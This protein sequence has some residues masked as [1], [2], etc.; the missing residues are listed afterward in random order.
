[1]LNKPALLIHQIH[2]PEALQP[3]EGRDSITTR[4]PIYYPSPENGWQE[5]DDNCSTHWGWGDGWTLEWGVRPTSHSC[6]ILPWFGAQTWTNNCIIYSLFLLRRLC[7]WPRL[8]TPFLKTPKSRNLKLQLKSIFNVRPACNTERTAQLYLVYR[9]LNC[10]S[11]ALTK[12]SKNLWR[13]HKNKL[14][15]K[16]FENS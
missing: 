10:N 16:V 1:M 14:P 12:F 4:L 7:Y 11:V 9:V 5:K 15:T 2:L 13:R 6:P 3:Q 8:A